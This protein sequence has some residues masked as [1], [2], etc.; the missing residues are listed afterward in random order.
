MFPD[1]NMIAHPQQTPAIGNGDIMNPYFPSPL[2]LLVPD[3][4]GVIRELPNVK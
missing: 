4:A 3:M 1:H 2:Q